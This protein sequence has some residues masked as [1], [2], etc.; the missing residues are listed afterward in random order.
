MGNPKEIPYL[1]EVLIYLI[2]YFVIFF[3][4]REGLVYLGLF[5][6]MFLLILALFLAFPIKIYYLPLFVIT[7][8][9]FYYLGIFLSSDFLLLFVYILNTLINTFIIMIYIK[10]NI[11]KKKDS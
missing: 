2:K 10:F 7:Y 11:V 5:D 1:K 4:L 9:V 8:F 6:S 3:I